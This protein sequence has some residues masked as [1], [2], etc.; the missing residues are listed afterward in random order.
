MIDT[1]PHIANSPRTGSGDSRHRRHFPA[2][3][4]AILAPCCLV[5]GYFAR[6]L[7]GVKSG[8]VAEGQENTGIAA[9]F[10]T[11]QPG[12]WGDIEVTPIRIDPPEEF[13]SINV[14]ERVDRRWHFPG[15]S[16]DDIKALFFKADLTESQRAALMDVSKWEQADGVTII[17]PD[18]ELVLSLSPDARKVIYNALMQ[19]PGSI[20][21][22]V[23]CAYPT[24]GFEEFFGKR[25]ISPE[26]LAMIKRLSFGHGSLQFFCDAPLVLGAARTHPEKV[27]ILRALLQKPTL[28]LKLHI[29]PESDIQELT[30]YWFKGN[31]GKDV[32]PI[33]SA[34]S[35]VPG[36]ARLGV[37]HML[38]PGPTKDLYTYPL[39][40]TDPADLHKDC[41]WTALNFFKDP[42]DPRFTNPDEVRQAY[43]NDYFPVLTDPRYGDI[44][45]LKR[46]D[47]SAI[48]SAVFIADDVVYT[49]N[50]NLFRDPFIFMRIPDMLQEFQAQVDENEQLKTV[51]YRSKY[52]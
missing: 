30:N 15:A 35:R 14:L 52:R 24:S 42:P 11:L 28:I 7:M 51:Y 10:T 33:L 36:G 8:S 22:R 6:E 32:R 12:P 31:V 20:L 48:H 2:W 29:T 9:R 46:P 37:I 34:I 27:R 40:S 16:Y 17:S 5:L 41:H 3:A 21:G 38:P 13:L 47:G 1:P 26:I 4:C 44:V 39:P 43:N 23:R 19:Y 45:V 49:K 50:S 25:G 18:D